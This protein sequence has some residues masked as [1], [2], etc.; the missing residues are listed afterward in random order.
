[1]KLLIKTSDAEALE[2]TTI[3]MDALEQAV[4]HPN[5]TVTIDVALTESYELLDDALF[6]LIAEGNEAAWRIRLQKHTLH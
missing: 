5:K 2:W 1:V 6:A 4:K 3:V